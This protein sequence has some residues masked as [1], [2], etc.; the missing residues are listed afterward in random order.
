MSSDVCA[1]VEGGSNLLLASIPK[2][3]SFQAAICRL[4]EDGQWGSKFPKLTWHHFPGGYTPGEARRLFRDLKQIRKGLMRV[5]YP[6]IKSGSGHMSEEMCASDKRGDHGSELGWRGGVEYGVDYQGIWIRLIGRPKRENM[7]VARL[8]ADHGTKVK[9]LQ[10]LYLRKVSLRGNRSLVELI[11]GQSIDADRRVFD[12][13][14]FSHRCRRIEFGM[15]RASTIFDSIISEL[16]RLCVESIT[17][18]QPIVYE[19]DIPSED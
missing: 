13:F 11:S 6:V 7:Y 17:L 16:E 1:Y 14:S 18:K 9:G 19:V 5:Y 15:V 12:L 2:F 10:T 3:F 4:L 8:I